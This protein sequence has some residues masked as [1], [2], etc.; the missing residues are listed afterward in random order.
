MFPE[1]IFAVRALV[2]P[3][4]EA[5]FNAWY[6]SKH[7]ADVLKLPGCQGAARYKLGDVDGRRQYLAVYAFESTAAIQAGLA[8]EHFKYL[9][10]DF[11]ANVG[12]FSQ[13]ARAIAEKVFELAPDSSG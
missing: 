4:H 3:A 10:A 9:V 1:H 13:R 7:L 6:N 2:D 8:S 5:E 12:R 11:D